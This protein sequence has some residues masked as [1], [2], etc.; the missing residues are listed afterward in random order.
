MPTRKDGF[1][2]PRQHP[3]TDT[4]N[5]AQNVIL[6]GEVKFFLDSWRLRN[7]EQR[8]YIERGA[9]HVLLCRSI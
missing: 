9:L 1:I 2:A 8:G 6:T 5:E 7:T 3:G 4:A